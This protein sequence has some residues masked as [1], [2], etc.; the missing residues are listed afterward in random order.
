MTSKRDR[1]F[2]ISPNNRAH[3]LEIELATDNVKELKVSD[4]VLAAITVDDSGM[5]YAISKD[6]HLYNMNWDQDGKVTLKSFKIKEGRTFSSRLHLCR[7]SLQRWVYLRNR[8][9][10]N[11]QLGDEQDIHVQLQDRVGRKV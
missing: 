4:S 2:M 6:G 1:V 7:Y 3:L 11:C 10:S 8:L 9:P 5:V